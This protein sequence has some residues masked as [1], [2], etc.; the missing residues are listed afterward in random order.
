MSPLGFVQYIFSKF[1]KYHINLK[2]GTIINALFQMMKSQMQ[3]FS[4]VKN[5]PF[6]FEL[7]KVDFM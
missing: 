5:I 3:L 1:Y 4:L 2:H 7:Q 6:E